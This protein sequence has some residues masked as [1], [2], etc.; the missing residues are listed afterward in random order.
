MQQRNANPAISKKPPKKPMQLELGL[1]NESGRRGG[2]PSR[3]AEKIILH[4]AIPEVFS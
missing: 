1:K 2:N 4:N 3:N